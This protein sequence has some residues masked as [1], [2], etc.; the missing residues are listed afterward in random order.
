MQD[1]LPFAVW[2][3]ELSWLALTIAG[4]WRTFAKAGAPGW[5]ALVPVYNFVVLARIGREKPGWALL[6]LV[7]LVNVFVIGYISVRVARRFGR[8]LPFGVGLMLLPMIF[9]PLLGFGACKLQE[10]R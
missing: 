8:G 10:A 7:P 1:L 2:L 3:L 6:L 4:V 9:Y 5:A